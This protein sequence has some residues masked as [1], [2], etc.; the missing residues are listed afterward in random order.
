M[1]K[2]TAF[3]RFEEVG[4]P[5]MSRWMEKVGALGKKGI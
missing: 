1:I 3:D 5:K 2:K 4:E